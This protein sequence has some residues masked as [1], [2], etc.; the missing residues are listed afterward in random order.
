MTLCNPMDCSP[1]GSSIPGIFQ[2]RILEW[3]TIS[4]LSYFYSLNIT[5]LKIYWD[6]SILISPWTLETADLSILFKFSCSE[7]IIQLE[8]CHM[9]LA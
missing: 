9:F 3:V 2:A 8:P 5:P 7:N 1:P 4:Y 6:F